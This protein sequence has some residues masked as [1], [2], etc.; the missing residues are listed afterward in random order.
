M[1]NEVW[2]PI[3]AAIVDFWET[4]KIGGVSVKGI[5]TGVGLV[6]G[7]YAVYKI[8]KIIRGI[9]RFVKAT[10]KAFKLVAK[11]IKL[12]GNK[13][14]VKFPKRVPKSPKPLKPPRKP[15]KPPKPPRKPPK[16]SKPP[17]KP[18]KPSK[19]LKPP[20]KPGIAKKTIDA[21]KNSKLVSKAKGLGSAIAASKVG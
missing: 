15:P 13:L 6:V 5:I 14:G 7:A 20:S 1:T 8:F 12:I 17:R 11:F 4:G 19:P 18:P 9:W 10:Y 16:P 21:L 3:K 2:K